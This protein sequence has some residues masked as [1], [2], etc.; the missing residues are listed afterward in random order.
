MMVEFDQIGVQWQYYEWQ[1]VV[2]D[3]DVCGGWG[4]QDLQWCID[5]V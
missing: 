2:Y 3:V 5:Q 1:V 4:V